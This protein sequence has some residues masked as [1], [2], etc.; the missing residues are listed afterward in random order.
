M[1]MLFALTSFAAD[2]TQEIPHFDIRSYQVEGNTILAADK[3]NSIVAPFTGKGKDFGT[4]QEALEALEKA[5]H[6]RGYIAVQVTLPE[7]ELEN[8]VVRL[9]V[10]ETLIGKIKIEGNQFFDESNIRRSLPELREGQTPDINVISK[11]LKLANE[12]PAKKVALRLQS[13]DQDNEVDA[14]L[15]VKDEKP[16]KVGLNFDNT[17][18]DKTGR[19]R[20][21]VLFQHANIFNR[22]QLLTLQYIT[23]T[24]HPENVSIYGMGYRIPLYGLG[25][26]IDLIGA[27][28]SV[29]SGTLT[30]ASNLLQV[31]GQ[32]TTLGLH[33]N[34]NFTRI[35][36]Y[37]H[38]LTLALD[39]RAYINSVAFGSVQLGNN[40][41]VH[42]LSLTYAGSWSLERT[43]AGFYLGV[44][45]NLP[46]IGE[47]DRDTKDFFEKVR[48]GAP[49]GYNV[50]RLGANILYAFGNDWQT[51]AV[52][53][54]QYT[55]NPL[56]SG[57][58]FGIGGASSVRGFDERVVSNDRGV[59]GSL[60]LYTPN[61]SGLV[62]ISPSSV[63]CRALF[64]YDMG[65]VAEV[66]PLPGEISSNTISSAGIGIRITDGK[67]L[68]ITSDYGFILEPLAG[69]KGTGSGRW[70]LAMSLMY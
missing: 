35:G 11:S 67:Y 47:G 5:Y 49:V 10:I 32:G 61:L 58:Q 57:E 37:E 34:Q 60:E 3:I 7:Q 22:D 68:S 31:S 30:V 62:R 19:F 53:N 26:S 59:S 24:I 44:S 56:V 38:K 65:Y 21:G 15:D 64:F 29:N 54:G 43:N 52:V 12:S 40:L 20:M 14:K 23:S 48:V 4:V 33:Y 16:W 63:Q 69:G 2:D 36:N 6:D 1:F 50:F 8:G 18:D 41:T 55:Y 39:Y 27:Y 51:R 9:N 45:R 46:G 28:S 70:H 42:P 66:N 25:S 17:G 13:S